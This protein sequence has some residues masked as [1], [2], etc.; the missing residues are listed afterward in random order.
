MQ[1]NFL[2]SE[3]FLYFGQFVYAEQI[4]PIV[5]LRILKSFYRFKTF[6]SKFVVQ[7]VD[8]LDILADF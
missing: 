8:L 1:Y 4:A 7:P 6:T 3:A 5:K 2:K